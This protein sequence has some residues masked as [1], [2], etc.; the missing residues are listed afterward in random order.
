MIK[1]NNADTTSYSGDSS[2]YKTDSGDSADDSSEYKTISE[3]DDKNESEDKRYLS[4]AD[5]FFCLGT[6][7]E[8]GTRSATHTP[9]LTKAEMYYRKAASMGHEAAA[10]RLRVIITSQLEINSNC[11]NEPLIFS[12]RDTP[13]YYLAESPKNNKKSCCTSKCILM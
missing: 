6:Q 13:E 11:S 9:N 4:L 1:T 10:Y 8:Y 2:E 7:A 5:E 12:Y 3:Y